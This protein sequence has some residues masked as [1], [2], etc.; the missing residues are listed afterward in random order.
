MNAKKSNS[1]LF[2]KK[3]TNE[4]EINNKLYHVKNREA[5]KKYKKDGHEVLKFRYINAQWRNHLIKV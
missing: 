1:F 4:K 2:S 3:G 5:I